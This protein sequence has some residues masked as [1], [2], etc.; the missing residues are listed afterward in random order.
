[1]RTTTRK[2]L[3]WLLGPHEEKEYKVWM[4]ADVDSQHGLFRSFQNDWNRL[5]ANGRRKVRISIAARTVRTHD[6]TII[7][8]VTGE[9]S[10]R[11]HAMTYNVVEVIPVE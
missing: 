6:A 1:M 3:V 2:E 8:V 11:E 10:R 7:V 9:E 5:T 4:V